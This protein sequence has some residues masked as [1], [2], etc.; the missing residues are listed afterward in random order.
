MRRFAFV[1]ATAGLR[2]RAAVRELILAVKFHERPEGLQPLVAPLSRAIRERGFDARVERVVAV[3]LHPLRRFVRGFDQ[4]ELLGRAVAADLGLPFEP[5][6]LRR[7]VFRR[8]QSLAEK[9]RRF[10]NLEGG[11]APGRRAH[12]VRG[13][14]VL[15]IDDVLTSGATADAAAR[16]LRAA[17]AKRVYVA[18]A[19][20]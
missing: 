3:P 10:A 20:T 7:R 13:K 14:R 2:Y 19:A 15:L 1:A 6:V 12:A 18:V 8:P 11:F 17:G 16:A 4:A 9:E 5:R